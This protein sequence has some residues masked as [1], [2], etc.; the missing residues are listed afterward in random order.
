MNDL[1]NR[2]AT[3]LSKSGVKVRADDL[4]SFH[5]NSGDNKT[6][7]LRDRSP[8]SEKII[9]PSVTVKFKTIHFFIFL[10]F[11]LKPLIL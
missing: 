3:A 4:S 2:V 6:V 11:L 9:P 1:G 7:T 5:R 10:I 8:R